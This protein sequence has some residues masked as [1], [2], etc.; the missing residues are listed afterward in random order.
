MFLL[1]I[2]AAICAMLY[3]KIG[4]KQGLNVSD[5]FGTEISFT[6]SIAVSA[7]SCA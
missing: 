6:N 2:I 3:I 1:K 5:N 4:Y 7:I